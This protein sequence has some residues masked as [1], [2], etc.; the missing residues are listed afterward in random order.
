MFNRQP[1]RGFPRKDTGT[2]TARDIV[3][4]PVFLLVFVNVPRICSYIIGRA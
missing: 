3:L 4:N 1:I 2:R